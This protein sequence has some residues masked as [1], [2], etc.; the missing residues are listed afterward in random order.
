MD[1]WEKKCKELCREIVMSVGHC[2]SS[3]K[4][5]G[6]EQHHGL[7]KSSQRLKLNRELKYDPDLQFC[8]NDESH[9]ENP[10]SS[11]KD[12][13]KFLASMIKA[14]GRTKYK[15][16]KIQKVNQG[17]LIRKRPDFERVYLELKGE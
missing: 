6:L 2:E 9:R 16:R 3:G 5:F 10:D 11:H 13:D 15:A 14:G 12:N 7:F 17:A 1:K 4:T 8:L